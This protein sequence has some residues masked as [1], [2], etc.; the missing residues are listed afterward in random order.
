M[1]VRRIAICFM[2]GTA[3]LAG[4]AS[5]QEQDHTPQLLLAPKLLRR[6]QRDRQRQTVRWLNF[7]RRVQTVPDS[8]ERGFELGLYYAVTHDQQRGREAVQWALT[9]SCERRQAALVLDWAANEISPEA[10]ARL[11]QAHCATSNA[12]DSIEQV[13]DNLFSAVVRGQD[14]HGVITGEWPSVRATIER[15][16]TPSN[17]YALSE[18]LMVARNS[19]RTD[20]R[21]DDP[22]FFSLLPKEFLLSLKPEQ[23]EHPSWIAHIAALALVTVDPNLENSQFLQGWAMEDRQMLRDGPGVAY[24]FMWGDP[25]LPGVAY[26][27]MDPWIYDPS[28]RLF[29]RTDWNAD[30]CWIA[31]TPAKLQKENCPANWPEDVQAPTTSRTTQDPRSQQISFG[32]LTLAQLLSSCLEV[33]RRKTNETMMLWNLKP[34]TE[35]IY[36]YGGRH[37]SGRIDSAGIWPVPNETSGKVCIARPGGR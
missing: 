12:S 35:L 18:F 25:Y 2:T 19:E 33:P 37:L 3:L 9:H 13:R 10:R 16:P 20:L 1:R 32:T 29:A 28:G 17:L 22:H 6:L 15:R 34:N 4:W 5:A 36:E 21:A 30:A 11:E 7:E 14:A 26:Q 8:P 27:N 23:A 31:I 24:E